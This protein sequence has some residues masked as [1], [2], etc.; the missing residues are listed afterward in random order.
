MTDRV[1]GRTERRGYLQELERAKAEM[2]EHI[3]DLEKVL[4]NHGIEVKPW[5]YAPY[6]HPPSGITYDQKGHPVEDSAE[7]DSWVQVG[8][9][10]VRNHQHRKKTPTTKSITR[11]RYVSPPAALHLGVGPDSA[12]LS[13][14][15]GTQLTILGTTIDLASFDVPDIDE[16][17]PGAEVAQPLYNK[18]IQAF[19]QS[20]MN[21][22]PRQHVEL[23]SREE[24]FKCSEW[25]FFIVFPFLPVLHK[26]TYMAL[27]STC[28]S[29]FLFHLSSFSSNPYSSLVSTTTRLLSRRPPNSSSCI[30]SWPSS[31]T[32]K[33]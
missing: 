6:G 20:M 3:R 4:A 13:S 27:V 22:N 17:S 11:S 10:W 30:W 19:L 15:K 28:F 8:S 33:P 12:P 1:T 24:A 7:K 29:F 21:V 23:P 9:V 14:I 25:Y 18:S 2:E 26:P 32:S 31:T 5:N 16:P